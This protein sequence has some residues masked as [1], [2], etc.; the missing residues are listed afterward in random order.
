VEE[1]LAL[2]VLLLREDPSWDEKRIREA[3]DSGERVEIALPAPVAI[4]TSYW[5][6]LADDSERV[7]FHQDLYG[8]DAALLRALDGAS[9]R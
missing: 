1:P 6:A 7:S 2:A 4:Q 8:I 9:A 5:T 3:I